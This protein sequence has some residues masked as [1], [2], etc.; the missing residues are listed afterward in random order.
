MID[1]VGYNTAFFFG[2]A[3]MV[4]AAVMMITL[5]YTETTPKRP[6]KI[7]MDN[8]VV[9]FYKGRKRTSIKSGS[10]AASEKMAQKNT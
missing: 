10:F 1:I 2:A 5:K 4:V 6:F 7:S 3:V 9:I 8:I